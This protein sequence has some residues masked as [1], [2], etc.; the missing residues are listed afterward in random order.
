[1]TA[2]V[3]VSARAPPTVKPIAVNPVMRSATLPKAP[4]YCV[5][6]PVTALDRKTPFAVVELFTHTKSGANPPV[7]TPC[8]LPVPV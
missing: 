6:S 5:L 8:G 1:M 3:F 2:L 7:G 4:K